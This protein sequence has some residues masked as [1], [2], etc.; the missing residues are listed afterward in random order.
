M[1]HPNAVNEMPLHPQVLVETFEKWTLDFVGPIN[2]SSKKKIYISICIE[3]VTKWAEAKALFKANEQSV[4]D[5][6]FEY[7]FVHFG[8]PKE[9]FT[10]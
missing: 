7:I 8:I 2:P 10:D 9:I 1:G 6:H 5:F 4:A 3:Y